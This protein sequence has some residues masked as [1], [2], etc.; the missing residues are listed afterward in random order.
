MEVFFNR[1]LSEKEIHSYE[2]EKEKIYRDLYSPFIKPVEGL[3]RFLIHLKSNQIPVSLA[4]SAPKVNVDFV[5]EK[6]DLVGYF[7]TILDSSFVEKGKPDPEIFL[8]EAQSLKMKPEFCIVIE[9]S[10]NGIEAARQA[11]MKVIGITTTLSKSKM[12]HVNLTI[13]DFHQLNIDMIRNLI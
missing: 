3:K 5:L 7:D 1:E 9:D 8:K 4:T 13:D 10:L 6:T 11:G 2:E 12:H